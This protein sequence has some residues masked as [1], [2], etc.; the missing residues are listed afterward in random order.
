ME[1]YGNLKENEDEAKD[2]FRNNTMSR[3]QLGKNFSIEEISDSSETS[4][5]QSEKDHEKDD[6]KVRDSRKTMNKKKLESLNRSVEKK[7]EIDRLRK[8]R[9]Q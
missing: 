6:R 9:N 1:F 5:F 2:R 8:N 3:R 4:G 7:I